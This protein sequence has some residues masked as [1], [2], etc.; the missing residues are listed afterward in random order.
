MAVISR[1][2][3]IYP[4]PN[5]IRHHPVG[6]LSSASFLASRRHRRLF[7]YVGDHAQSERSYRLK[8]SNLAIVVLGWD[9]QLEPQNSPV[10]G[11][12]L[13]RL[14]RDV[15]HYRCGRRPHRLESDRQNGGALATKLVRMS[16]Y[17]TTGWVT[18]SRPAIAGLTVLAVCCGCSPGRLVESAQLG[19]DA[20]T[21]TADPA[22][23]AKVAG[24]RA[25]RR[26]PVR[27][28]HLPAG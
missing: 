8:A 18:M 21:G 20:A 6:I 22:A 23:A 7:A 24:I 12:E 26:S 15:D 1:Q 19:I 3:A 27:R 5:D 2:A 14:R 25:K 9:E 4:S 16:I 11:N 13:G 17:R 28:G 10:V